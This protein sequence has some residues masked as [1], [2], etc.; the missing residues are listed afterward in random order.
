MKPG[1]I[2]RRAGLLLLAG[3]ILWLG[4]RGLSFR[5]Y[6]GSVPA[7]AA[8]MAA[9]QDFEIEG[10]YHLHSR[11]SDGHGTVDDIAAAAAGEGLDFVILTD[12][13]SPNR[14][15]LLAAG[16]KDGVLILAGTE[17]SS[18]R[19]HLVAMGFDPPDRDFSGTAELAAGEAAAL[20]GF[21]VLAH[22]YSKTAWSWGDW[23]GYSGLEIQNGDAVVKRAPARTLLF[24][25]LLLA[26]PDAALL[27]LV[28]RPRRETAAWDRWGVDRPVRGYF[29]S[30]AHFA[31][32]ALGRLF[33][34]HVLLDEPAAADFE[35]ARRQVFQALKGGLFYNAVEAAA[36][37]D[38]F[39]F[40][41]V[42]SG[43]IVPMGGTIAVGP[44]RD[45]DGPVRLIARTPF[46][47]AH[48]T[49]L[50]RAG[51]T[52]ASGSGPEL[53]F[54]TNDPGSYRVEVFLRERTPLGA[55]VPWIASN[56]IFFSKDRP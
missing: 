44:E 14:E 43:K 54:E 18:S 1:R 5:R 29:A 50:L 7:A 36:E 20:G 53:V 23:A 19:G 38:G 30:D 26:R 3:Y 35:A 25:P 22:P 45:A 24:A 28:G 48:E 56:V 51:I 37:A 46:A 41:A 17:I 39:R 9:P 47:F 34:L 49:R 4:W 21:T 16:R 11:F 15:T 32:G 2:L 40:W 12:H 10:V 27:A 42:H 55:E 52:V 6:A 33:R 8:G 31:Y 13:G